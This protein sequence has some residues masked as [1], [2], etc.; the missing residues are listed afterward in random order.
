MHA[1]RKHPFIS[2]FVVF[3][4]ILI[5]V[6][7]VGFLIGAN[8]LTSPCAHD[9]SVCDGPAM[10]AMSVWYLSFVGGIVFALICGATSLFFLLIFNEEENT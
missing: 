7:L 2:S 6:W 8:A 5:G 10:F 3:L 9:D 1:I 4:G